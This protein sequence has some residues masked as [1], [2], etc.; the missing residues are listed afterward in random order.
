[1]TDNPARIWPVDLCNPDEI[2]DSS[3]KDEM[4]A[5]LIRHLKTLVQERDKLTNEVVD[6]TIK[7]AASLDCQTGSNGGSASPNAANGIVRERNHLALEVSELKA[8]IRAL[9]QEMQ[10]KTDVSSECKEEVEKYITKCS[11]LRQENLELSQKARE[12]R[13]LKDELDVQRERAQKVH[14]L[15]AEI[16]VTGIRL[17]LAPPVE[18]HF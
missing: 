11:K 13:A 6:L 5:L 14:A 10:E 12:A 9:N 3:K 4:Y 18:C 7:A 8:K 2:S 17:N 16:Q 1:M 15:E